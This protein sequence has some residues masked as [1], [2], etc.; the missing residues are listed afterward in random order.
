VSKIIADPEA[1]TVALAALTKMVSLL[2]AELVVGQ[3][4]DDI[5]ALEAAI[6]AKL[7]ASVDGVS[8]EATAAGISLA[9]RLLN[10]VLRDLRSRVEA[11]VSSEAQTAIDA[12]NP[13]TNAFDRRKLN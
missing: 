12:G 13:T 4:S 10:P 9:H 3:H 8:P 7:F 1:A 6:R 5:D 11:K 2:A